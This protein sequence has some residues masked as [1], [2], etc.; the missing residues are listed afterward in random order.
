MPELFDI[1][2]KT[3]VKLSAPTSLGLNDTTYTVIPY[4]EVVLNRGALHANLPSVVVDK[5][6]YYE[7]KI[8]IDAAFPGQ[9]ELQAMAFINGAAASPNA[10]AIQGR[11]ANKPVSMYWAV[12]VQLNA[13]DSIDVRAKNGDNGDVT[14]DFI[15]S[16]LTVESDS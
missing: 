5:S 3:A 15:R 1:L 12:T 4:D 13:G 16:K 2:G 11:G 6:G 7:V 8:G 9:E 10:M 14:L